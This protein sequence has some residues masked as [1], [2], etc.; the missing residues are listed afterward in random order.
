MQSDRVF[1]GLT[2]HSNP[3]I[4]ITGRNNSPRSVLLAQLSVLRLGVHFPHFLNLPIQLLIAI[5]S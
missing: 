5:V 4:Q 2:V 1:L 3:P